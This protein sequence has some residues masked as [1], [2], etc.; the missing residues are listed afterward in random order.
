MLRAYGGMLSQWDAN[1]MWTP[2]KHCSRNA[3]TS[4]LQF[5]CQAG[6]FIAT[7]FT[8]R[9]EKTVTSSGNARIADDRGSQL[10]RDRQSI[11]PPQ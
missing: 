6:S 10:R 9:P 3:P 8:R 4:R 1:S 5:N 7:V 11:R 2:G